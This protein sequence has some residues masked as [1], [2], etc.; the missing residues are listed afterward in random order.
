MVVLGTLGV[1]EEEVEETHGGTQVKE[2]NH[3]P[4]LQEDPIPVRELTLSKVMVADEADVEG[5]ATP[6][7]MTTM[8]MVGV[9][10]VLDM[11]K[12]VTRH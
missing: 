6:M 2:Q 4:D 8:A 7:M 10:V 12:T 1:M 5:A 3:L 11:T 9:N